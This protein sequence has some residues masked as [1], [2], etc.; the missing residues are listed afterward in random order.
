MTPQPMTK[1][2]KS[3]DPSTRVARDATAVV[4]YGLARSASGLTMLVGWPAM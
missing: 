1:L 4:I 2:P 3:S